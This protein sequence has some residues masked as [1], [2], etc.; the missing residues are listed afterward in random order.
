MHAPATLQRIVLLLST[1]TTANHAI[2]AGQE[3]GPRTLVVTTDA[4][5]NMPATAPHA[6]D[7]MPATAPQPLPWIRGGRTGGTHRDPMTTEAVLAPPHWTST[8]D[9][10]PEHEGP[11]AW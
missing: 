7:S 10:Q 8:H 5:D 3:P 11:T 4:D 2:V 1:T 9:K 6:D